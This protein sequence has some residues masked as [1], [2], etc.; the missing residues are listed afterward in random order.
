MGHDIFNDLYRTDAI[1]KRHVNSPRRI[2]PLTRPPQIFLCGQEYP[3]QL[4]AREPF[5][6]RGKI[7]GFLDF[8]EHEPLSAAKNQINFAAAPAPS[9]VF[10]HM[11]RPFVV[12]CH[13]P[14]SRQPGMV[15]NRAAQFCLP[16]A[17]A[18]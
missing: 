6:R 18:A 5:G 1:D 3:L 7:P 8:H 12:A 9:P 15:G 11:A 17:N 4:P 10:Q 2:Q 16:M 13:K 14:L